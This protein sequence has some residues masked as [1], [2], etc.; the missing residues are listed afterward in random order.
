MEKIEKV[1]IGALFTS[2]KMNEIITSLNELQDKVEKNE[3]RIAEVQKKAGHY[4][5]D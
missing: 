2:K 5:V 3:K 1:K 4:V